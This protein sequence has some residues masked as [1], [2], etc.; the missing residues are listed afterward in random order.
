MGST[1]K[2]SGSSREPARIPYLPNEI[3]HQILGYLPDLSTLFEITKIVLPTTLES[4][5]WALFSQYVDRHPLQ[6]QK[7]VRFVMCVRYGRIPR[8]RKLRKYLVSNLGNSQSLP[9]STISVLR[10]LFNYY[11][12][13][14]KCRTLLARHQ[15]KIPPLLILDS[16]HDPANMLQ[17]MSIVSSDIE[18]LVRS[19]FG[20]RLRRTHMRMRDLMT[21]EYQDRFRHCNSEGYSEAVHEKHWRDSY[22][23]EAYYNTVGAAQNLSIPEIDI[24]PAPPSHT[25]LHRLRRAFW[26]LLLHSDLFHGPNAKYRVIHKGEDSDSGR[27]LSFPSI[28]KLWELEEM[29]CAYHHLREQTELWAD[30][31][32]ASYLPDLASRLLNNFGLF[33]DVFHQPHG[34]ENPEMAEAKRHITSRWEDYREFLW[35]CRE[36]ITETRWP[37]ISDANR[38]NAGWLYFI[39]NYRY[40]NVRAGNDRT[41]SVSC[42]LGWGY[43][44]WDRSRLE[45]WWL[46]DH[47][48]TSLLG[49]KAKSAWWAC[50]Q[51]VH[52][53][54]A[55]CRLLWKPEPETLESLLA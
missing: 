1:R 43:C 28:L 45:S 36:Q 39:E 31:Q 33:Q 37:D 47:R 4:P 34:L 10:K 13:D 53:D 21:E 38:P 23:L 32:S 11:N 42:F 17:D 16:I 20:T 2:M 44:I 15:W 3:I 48:G 26:R 8:N 40:L 50:S 7:L 14:K 41:E 30:P 35:S 6:L 54:C 18:Q 12:S 27:T 46:L 22:C 19:F 9:I 25:E 55:H 51:S 49:G 5:P 29:E 52:S 24:D